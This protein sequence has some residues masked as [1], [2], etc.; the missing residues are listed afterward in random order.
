MLHPGNILWIRTG[1]IY[2]S[3]YFESPRRHYFKLVD[4]ID[5]S[6][7]LKHPKKLF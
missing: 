1:V 5:T 2:I 4:N 3:H 7:F 6:I